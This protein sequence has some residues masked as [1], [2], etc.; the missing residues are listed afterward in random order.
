M[1]ERLQQALLALTR[2]G[3]EED[4]V[5]K[6]RLLRAGAARSGPEPLAKALA[7]M[8][9]IE[10]MHREEASSWVQPECL[11]SGGGGRFDALGLLH[12]LAL[13]ERAGVACVPAR[14]ILELT[15]EE[16]SVLSGTLRLPEDAPSRRL[17]QSLGKAAER[18]GWRKDGKDG[19]DGQDGQDAPVEHDMEALKEKLAAAM[20]L[21]PE[22][23][24]VRSTR[25]GPSS[26]KALA[27]AGIAGPAAPEVRFGPGLEAG[28]GWNRIGNRRY[29]D[30]SDKRIMAA[31]A[32]VPGGPCTFVARPW[33]RASRWR[34]GDDPHRHGTPFQG[35]GFW[36]AEWR[37]FVERSR[38]VGVSF[39]YAWAGGRSPEDA[40][41]A[42]EARDLAQAIVDEAC[43]QGACPVTM[44]VEFARRGSP[45]ID[46]RFPKD[47]VSCTLDFI[48]TEQGL[49]LLEG[50]PPYTPVG[51]GHP[52]GFAGVEAPSGVAFRP[53]PGV[54]LGDP[55]TWAAV[56]EDRKGC[57]VTWEEAA[58]LAQGLHQEQGTSP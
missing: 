37:C 12:W 58:E 19:Q 35:P 41:A 1:I 5:R 14:T 52:C 13:A 53:L 3:E 32:E 44:P 49:L 29:V 16:M 4:L 42:L 17:S 26:L 33:T 46:T 57:H 21:V 7:G 25:V 6:A 54:L 27:G 40:K 55:R 34:T 8:A 31:Y 20:D 50:G 43:R 36:P 30:P 10:R 15:E 24:M 2:Q 39:Y 9:E 45:A 28:P 18:L 56:G 51:S 38:V 23:W 22:G 47:T 11:S 48:E